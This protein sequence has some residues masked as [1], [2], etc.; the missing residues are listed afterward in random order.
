MQSG[1][2]KN[3]N[4]KD[5]SY[6]SSKT[7]FLNDVQVELFQNFDKKKENV[8]NIMKYLLDATI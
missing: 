2:S 1:G 3:N 4:F 8:Q 6:Y 7:K 5:G